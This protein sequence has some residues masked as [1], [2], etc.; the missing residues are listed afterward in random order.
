MRGAEVENF[1]KGN[2]RTTVA[3]TQAAINSRILR[4][5][6]NLPFAR[7]FSFQKKNIDYSSTIAS[8]GQSATHV[9]QEIHLS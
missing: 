6:M 2:T 3:A 4:N 5:T 7:M 1:H 9:P 8:A